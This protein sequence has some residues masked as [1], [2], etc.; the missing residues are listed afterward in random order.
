M[1]D[2]CNVI[3]TRFRKPG[4]QLPLRL[5]PKGSL[6]NHKPRTLAEATLDKVAGLL[7]PITPDMSVSERTARISA[8]RVAIQIARGK[9]GGDAA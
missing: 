2:D 3:A 1:S 6:E 8:A 4:A 5:V 7:A 9:P